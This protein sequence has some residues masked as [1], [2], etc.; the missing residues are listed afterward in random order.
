MNAKH[1]IG[2]LAFLAL[3]LACFLVFFTALPTG[4]KGKGSLTVTYAGLTNDPSGV[5][6]VQFKVANAYPRRINFGIG[7][8]QVLQSNTW[9]NWMRIAGGSNWLAVAVGSDRVFSI[10]ASS[11][12]G[13]A[14]R[15]PLMYAEDPSTIDDLRWRVRGIAW[16][17]SHWR[18]GHPLPSPPYG[19]QAS[20]AFSPE[21]RGLS[22]RFDQRTNVDSSTDKANHTS[23]AS[24]S[25]R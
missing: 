9:P 10:D 20:I 17:I 25:H 12:G 13:A 6:L 2:A 11:L 22:P 1:L 19:H 16:V 14:W 15:V 5:R 8:V 21:M 18:P 24:E 7:E 23:Q 4:P 3:C